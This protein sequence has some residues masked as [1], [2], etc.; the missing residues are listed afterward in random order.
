MTT[1][2]ISLRNVGLLRHP[3]LISPPPPAA[4]EVWTEAG[5]PLPAP[6]YGTKLEIMRIC[7]C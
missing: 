5:D 2:F 4:C 1:Y 3:E 7:A 6:I